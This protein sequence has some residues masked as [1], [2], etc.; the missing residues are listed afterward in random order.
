MGSTI[1]DLPE[2]RA[3]ITP[4]LLSQG[5]PEPDEP[6]ENEVEAEPRLGRNVVSYLEPR[7]RIDGA[8]YFGQ[9][10]S[11]SSYVPEAAMRGVLRG[12]RCCKFG[13]DYPITDDSTC[14]LYSPNPNG[15]P[16]GHCQEHAGVKMI[17]G[18]RASV[19][20]WDVD[21]ARDQTKHCSGCR[22]IQ[23]GEKTTCALLAAMNE[24]MPAV[25]AMNVEIK[26]TGRCTL[27]TPPE[28]PEDYPT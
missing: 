3:K 8:E 20:P 4:R 6:E 2:P 27:W 13:D 9:C 14:N 28:P 19:D 24:E 25:F 15:T 10:A 11:C 16:C 22:H 1:F 21:Y 26:L 18:M 5:D 12:D 7:E 17:A 23:F